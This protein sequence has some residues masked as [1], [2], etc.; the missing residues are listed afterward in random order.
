MSKNSFITCILVL[1]LK[2][3]LIAQVTG[4]FTYGIFNSP[5]GQAYIET[6]VTLIGNSIKA[7]KI[8]RNSKQSAVNILFSLFKD[9][10]VASAKKYNLLGPAFK[11]SVGVN[12]PNFLDVQRYPIANGTYTAIVEINDNNI[13]LQS[14]FIADEVFNVSYNPKNLQASSIQILESY[15]KSISPTVLTKS[16]FDLVPY[17]SNLFPETQNFLNF[18]FE[19]YNADTVLGKNKNFIFS[20][21][22]ETAKQLT[23]LE[24][25]G[26]FKKQKTEK[27][28]PLLAKVDLAKL[29]NGAYNL[30]IE[31]RDE[32][33]K[34]QLER[35]FAFVRESKKIDASEILANEDSRT[36]ESYFGACNNVD[37]LKLFTECLWPIANTL[38]KDRI[39]NATTKKDP[40][41]M[42]NF[43][44][45]FW[46]RYAAD[47]ANPLKLWG[48]YYKDLQTVLKNFKCAKRPGYYTD[49]GR[50]YMQYGA[51]NIRSQQF[52][53]QGTYPYEIWQYYRINDRSTGQF[54]T[55]RKFVFVNKMLGDDCYELIQS[56]MKGEVSNPRWKF[57]V[58]RQNNNG[59]GNI[60]NTTPT[61]SQSSHLD[62]IYANPR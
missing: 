18:Y 23:K 53:E 22:I 13:K 8:D 43:I 37:T 2:A 54:F 60:D 26:S 45:D 36:V 52:A 35:K 59:I 7:K 11:D 30:V 44:V 15:K 16:G 57:E 34:L 12:P 33:N 38:D 61:N 3:N 20:Y 25:F 56:D 27:V 29:K 24:N 21:F 10:V 58:L 50:V 1:F 28:N 17:N 6:Y 32:T 40:I 46:Q 51:P 48:T 62:E 55:N 5:G 14:P 47:T 49:R 31:V 41:L 39:I 19:L 42:K 9:T 4:Y